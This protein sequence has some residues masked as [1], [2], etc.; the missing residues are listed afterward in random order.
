[1]KKK[2]LGNNWIHF[3]S[4]SDNRTNN[5]WLQFLDWSDSLFNK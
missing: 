1:M 2:V 4:R 3:F 5:N